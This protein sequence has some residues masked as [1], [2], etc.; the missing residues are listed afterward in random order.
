MLEPSSSLPWGLCAS[1]WAL[2]LAAACTEI[3]PSSL[4]TSDAGA[5]PALDAGAPPPPDA[6]VMARTCSATLSLCDDRC[7]DLDRDP[8]HCGRCSRA[9]APDEVCATGACMLPVLGAITPTRGPTA[10]G[11][12]VRISGRLL[13]RLG[14][15]EVRFADRPAEIVARS[16][17]SVT[18]ELPPRPEQPGLV[19]VTASS[20]GAWS[21]R[22]VDAFRYEQAVLT[23]TPALAVDLS[24]EATGLI[25]A[26]LDRDGHLDAAWVAAADPR[27]HLGVMFGRGD[28]T[29]TAPELR[30]VT[31]SPAGLG[32]RDLNSDGYV[33]LVAFSASAQPPI[34]VFP[35]LRNRSFGAVFE[36][37]PGMQMR[38]DLDF[39]DF[40]EDG[41]VDV[42]VGGRS[43][44]VFARGQGNGTLVRGSQ[45]GAGGTRAVAVG[46]LDAQEDDHDDVL[47]IDESTYRLDV[48]FGRGDGTF[49]SEASYDVGGPGGQGFVVIADL[50][51]DGHQD[52]VTTTGG[53]AQV[54]LGS[55]LGI[56]SAPRSYATANSDPNLIE[57]VD[58][59]RDGDLDLAL[60][61][62]NG[63][64]FTLLIN[65]GDA[66]FERLIL[67]DINAPRYLRAGDFDED[68]RVDLLVTRS[69][70]TEATGSTSFWPAEPRETTHARP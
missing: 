27:N 15:L 50:D 17:E 5:A 68:G 52:V 57:V 9:C 60:G 54:L 41:R 23:F 8:Q 64:S 40:D 28:G 67:G 70:E 51:G 69:C 31:E 21:Q 32:A 26:D 42:V 65:R 3:A 19:D 34:S 33:E 24:G 20:T 66:V 29:F 11:V 25:V 36:L 53:A 56:L 61:A 44:W 13:D 2:G 47:V 30:E 62:R 63:T 48:Y 22:L 16:A 6:G 18:V 49:A 12:E 10:G 45:F 14:D 46:D 4:P 1:A 58:I 35:N 43:R 55:A 7:F 39:G 37:A 38:G 59:D